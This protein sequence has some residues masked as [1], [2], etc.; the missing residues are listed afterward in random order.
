MHWPAGIGEG[1]VVSFWKGVDGI[2]VGLKGGIQQSLLVYMVRI[3]GFHPGGP[4]S[5]PG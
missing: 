4:G 2:Y 3:P 5:I 1:G